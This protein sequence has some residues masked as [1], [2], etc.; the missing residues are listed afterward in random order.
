[1]Q[2]ALTKVFPS[3]LKNVIRSIDL[4]HVLFRCLQYEGLL[5]NLNLIYEIPFKQALY[6][7]HRCGP[8]EAKTCKKKN[9][10]SMEPVH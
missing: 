7:E 4:C 1:M 10:A 3:S 5:R 6:L 9:M 8:V 2:D